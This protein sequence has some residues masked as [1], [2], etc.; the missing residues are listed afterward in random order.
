MRKE[1]HCLVAGLPDLLF[2]ASK[3]NFSVSEFKSYLHEELEESD[4]RLIESYFWRYDNQNLLNLLNDTNSEWIKPANLGGE[5]FDTIFALVKDDALHDF[6][7]NIP[8]YLGRF[9]QM[10]KSDSSGNQSKSW[11][12]Q[13]TD[14]YYEYLLQTSNQFF[15][16][17]YEFELSLN[18][19]LTAAYCKKFEIPVEPQLIGSGEI[20]EKLI[21]SNARDFGIGNEFPKIEQIIRAIEETDL[22]EKE[23]KIDL[24][25]WELL[26]ERTFFHFF[27]VERIFAYTLKT[28]MIERWI[29]LDKKTGEEMFNKLLGELEGARNLSEEFGQ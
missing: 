27:T 6:E 23:K 9:I 1:Y 21:K 15:R 25:K 29:K 16:D 7:R 24:I 19:L 28:D 3:L 26:D 5:N 17:W 10:F 11:E 20:N 18:N 22:L 13:L 12:N 4:Y 14:F 2:D 8:P